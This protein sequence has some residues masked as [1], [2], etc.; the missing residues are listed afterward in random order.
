[1]PGCKQYSSYGLTSQLTN[2]SSISLS[3]VLLIIPSVELSQLMFQ[4]IALKALHLFKGT[5][6]L[7]CL[8]SLSIPY[9]PMYYDEDLNIVPHVL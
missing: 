1:M 9:I 6:T 2:L 8:S 4:H 7:N 3:L 5:I